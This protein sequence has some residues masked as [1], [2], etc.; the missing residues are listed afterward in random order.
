MTTPVLMV[1][2]DDAGSLG[3][4]DG[5][6]PGPGAG[7]DEGFHRGVSELLEE[8]AHEATPDACPRCGGHRL[9]SSTVLRKRREAGAHT[10]WSQEVLAVSQ[11]PLTSGGAFRATV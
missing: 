7:R 3:M 6:L 1:V 2:D 5:Y 10:S 9:P 11:R 8:W 4:I